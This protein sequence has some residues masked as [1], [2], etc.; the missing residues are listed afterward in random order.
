MSKHKDGNCILGGTQKRGAETTLGRE[1]KG[2]DQE[3]LNW[4][5]PRF[6]DRARNEAPQKAPPFLDPL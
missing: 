3:T 5:G 4:L 2:Y 1:A 6:I